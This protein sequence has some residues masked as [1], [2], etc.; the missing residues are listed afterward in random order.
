[1]SFTC[2]RV[3]VDTKERFHEHLK[4]HFKGDRLQNADDPFLCFVVGCSKTYNR[5]KSMIRHL[6]NRH[7]AVYLKIFGRETSSSSDSSDDQA[8]ADDK[9]GSNDFHLDNDSL[10]D[11]DDDFQFD[12]QSVHPMPPVPLADDSFTE[13]IKQIVEESFISNDLS[14]SLKA[15]LDLRTNT[16]SS[17][18]DFLSTVNG[19]VHILTE[20][21]NKGNFPQAAREIADLTKSSYAFRSTLN[22]EQPAFAFKEVKVELS[23]GQEVEYYYFSLRDIIKCYLNDKFLLTKILENY[24]RSPNADNI[25]EIEL[26]Y[27]FDDFN[28][29]DSQSAASSVHKLSAMFITINNVDYKYQCLVDDI[30]LSQLGHREVFDKLIKDK[31]KGAFFG[32]FISDFAGINNDPI[33]LKTKFGEFK[34]TVRLENIIGDNLALNELKN[35]TKSFLSNSCKWC[36]LHYREL[37]QNLPEVF[38]PRSDHDRHVFMECMRPGQD[39]NH[40]FCVDPFHDIC[41]GIVIYFLKYFIRKYYKSDFQK[42]FQSVQENFYLE[43][44]KLHFT[45]NIFRGSGSQYYE[46]FINFSLYDSR[47]DR[48]SDDFKFYTILR[49]V[50]AFVYSDNPDQFS[51][52][53]IDTFGCLVNQFYTFYINKILDKTN[54]D[55]KTAKFKFHHLQHYAEFL[56]Q[57]KNLR[58]L[59]TRRFERKNQQL[60]RF[61][62]PSN[63]QKNVAKEISQNLSI[64]FK[65]KFSRDTPEPVDNF[66]LIAFDKINADCSQFLDQTEPVFRANK[67][68]FDRLE[69][70]KGDIFLISKNPLE[71]IK[72][73]KIYR[74]ADQPVLVGK[75]IISLG[76]NDY[77]CAYEIENTGFLIK[78][79]PTSIK[80]H[81]KIHFQT[82][83]SLQLLPLLFYVV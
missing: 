34:F 9:I 16:H 26:E 19:V 38:P 82:V 56:R 54:E 36:F 67:L 53:E 14:D 43:H 12:N 79:H 47:V 62:K 72:V 5:K 59:D 6:K 25:V 44:G 42:Y 83:G 7:S 31:K 17:Q 30:F 1:M 46:F 81:K 3:S 50:M 29:L 52:Q 20:Q 66:E 71:F 40:L 27:Y 73:C 4:L 74:Q 11:F 76:F 22:E 61:H 69:I 57:G 48:N 39:S 55:V 23:D 32:E 51:D 58:R 21:F 49:N 35:I 65:E 8:A 64:Y 60:K 80:N 77:Y 33:V 10:P 2:C 70:C 68:E 78:I 37:Q 15:I 18:K 13:Q 45:K 28:P 63:C 41:H 24:F 75:K